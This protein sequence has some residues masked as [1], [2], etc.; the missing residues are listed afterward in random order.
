MAVGKRETHT[1]GRARELR[2]TMLFV[3]PPSAAIARKASEFGCITMLLP[4]SLLGR[5]FNHHQA[6]QAALPPDAG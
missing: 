4:R 1:K 6:G 5:K 2:P 3:C